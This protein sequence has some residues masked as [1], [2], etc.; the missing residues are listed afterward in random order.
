M[1]EW[2]L[3]DWGT[4]SLRAWVVDDTGTVLG[5]VLS[6]RGIGTLYPGESEAV[7]TTLVREGLGAF[8]LPTLLSGMVGSALGWAIAPYITAPANAEI[9]GEHVLS[10]GNNVWI[11]PGIRVQHVQYGPDVMRGEETQ[12]VGWLSLDDTRKTGRHLLCLP[13]THSKWV[14]IEEGV[15]TNFSTMMTGELFDLILKN[16]L[17]S[18]PPDTHEH[19]DAGVFCDG[20]AM[21]TIGLSAAL[22]SARARIVTGSMDVSST[23]SFVS[24]VLIG[25]ELISARALFGSEAV[26]H[27]VGE[28][29]L[30]LKYA[31]ALERT[32]QPSIITNGSEASRHGLHSIARGIPR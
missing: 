23:R 25:A 18:V 30:A 21:S 22:F 11:V 12:I 13:G 1:S 4:S 19:W 6:D 26:V 28:P 8:N 9:L 16:S 2:L 3:C 29:S 10:L 17:L 24:G 27:V 14:C 5:T 7:F 15:I 20:L 31:T 32:G